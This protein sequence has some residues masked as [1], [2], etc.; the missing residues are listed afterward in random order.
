M[1]KI[2]TL[3]FALFSLLVVTFAGSAKATTLPAEGGDTLTVASETKIETQTPEQ[4]AKKALDC[5]SVSSPEC[6]AYYDALTILL[7]EGNCDTNCKTPEDY[8]RNRGNCP[9]DASAPAKTVNKSVVAVKFE[10][11]VEPAVAVSGK[12][13]CPANLVLDEVNGS[14]SGGDGVAVK[15]YNRFQVQCVTK[16]EASRRAQLRTNT[17][18]GLICRLDSYPYTEEE[19]KVLKDKKIDVDKPLDP[20][21][22]RCELTSNHLLYLYLRKQAENNGLSTADKSSLKDI[23]VRAADERQALLNAV[24]PEIQKIVRAEVGAQVPPAVEKAIGDRGHHFELMLGPSYALRPAH[25]VA[26]TNSLMLSTNYIYSFRGKAG[27]MVSG[28]I[29]Y[30]QAREEMFMWKTSVEL[31]HIFNTSRVK[32]DPIW[33]GHLGACLE[34]GWLFRNIQ[35]EMQGGGCVGGQVILKETFVIDISLFA[36]TGRA[37]KYVNG[38]R[39]GVEPYS[40]VGRGS[41]A[42]GVANW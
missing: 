19:K 29:G 34:G 36:G 3:L 16:F 25:G 7:R 35:D 12:C 8:I 41:I 39:V 40:F 10:S 6:K 17:A 30:G 20:K 2:E 32:N 24:G 4:I 14:E 37:G 13:T 11:C 33:A 22:P 31:F 23:E 5:Q 15:E 26:N 38:D 28:G 27:I 18:L 21:D 42:V 9:P 1:K